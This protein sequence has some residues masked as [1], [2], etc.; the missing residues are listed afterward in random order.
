MPV[1]PSLKGHPPASAFE[2]ATYRRAYAR[3]YLLAVYAAC[4]L[5]HKHLRDVRQPRR[6]DEG[7]RSAALETKDLGSL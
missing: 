7:R 4:S 6:Q 5:N 3:W 2:M 1:A